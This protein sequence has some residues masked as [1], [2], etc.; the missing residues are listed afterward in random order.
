[1]SQASSN[2]AAASA[3][4]TVQTSSLT[5]H[6]A[7]LDDKAG[8]I[9]KELEPDQKSALGSFIR[10]LL[11]GQQF[12]DR[13]LTRAI[14]QRI[15][16]IDEAMQAQIN[17][18]LHHPDFQ[19]LEGTWRGLK[20]MMG[21]CEFGTRIKLQIF[22]ATKSELADMFEEF[23]GADYDQSPLFKQ[24]YQTGLNIYGG[25][26]YAAIVGDYELAHGP[27]DVRVLRGMGKLAAVCHAPFIA[28]TH[29]SLMKLKAWTEINNRANVSS[30]MD[31]IEYAGWNSFRESED[32]KYV[33]LTL[34]RFLARLPYGKDKKDIK[35]FAF[36]E[37]TAGQQHDR[38]CWANAAYAMGRRVLESF[39]D[40]EW[41]TQ[42]CGPEAGGRVDELPIDLHEGADGQ[43]HAKI[44][45]EVS[46][47]DDLERL[48]SMGDKKN[49]GMGLVPLVFRQN[50]DYAAFFSAQSMHKPK[51]FVGD[52]YSTSNS[53][54]GAQLHNIFACSR[55]AHYLKVMVR[56][57]IGG[58]ASTD[59]LRKYLYEW[60]QSYVEPNPDQVSDAQKAQRPLAE[61]DVVVQ[62]VPGQP[63]SYFAHFK[64]RPHYK[65]QA[66][67][68]AL[69]LVSTVKTGD[70]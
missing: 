19:K 14:K 26:P 37:D 17:V 2:A 33:A 55:F 42:I 13:N 5:D 54:L 50:S 27:E 41:C 65:L 56:D 60:I 38:Y 25:N 59:S 12:V 11:A 57:K 66:L 6:L 48:L 29:P 62:P 23:D 69:S 52:D 15:A 34:P 46:I 10:E 31:K 70:A 58:F 68:V 44:P 32:A 53:R 21:G 9:I 67:D 3:L 28:A 20:S 24:L 43:M 22:D 1:M 7:K 40:Y 61:A 36:E 39:N 47:A 35:A 63:G 4:D 51:E 18:I 8:K 49:A 45:T 16:D 64:L 30:G